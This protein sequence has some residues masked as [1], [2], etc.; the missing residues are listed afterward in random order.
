MICKC[1]LPFKSMGLEM[2]MFT[3]AAF[4]WSK[5]SKILLYLKKGLKSEYI[6]ICNLFQWREAEI[7]ASLLQSYDPAEIILICDL[8]L[9]KHLWF[10]SMLKTVVLFQIFVETMAHYF[11]HSMV[12]SKFKITAFIIYLIF[13]SIINVFY[14][15]FWSI[16]CILAE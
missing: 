6:L 11:H 9:K 12:N 10:L 2:L 14:C 13:G 5:Y 3:K 16:E 8:L 4:I 7:S 15:H 1:T